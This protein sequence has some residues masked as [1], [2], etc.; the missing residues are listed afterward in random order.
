MEIIKG[1]INGIGKRAAI[2]ASRTNEQIVRRLVE[3]ASNE[4]YRAGMEDGDIVLVEVPG[5]WEIAGCVEKLL[6]N[7]SDS[8]DMV[9]CLG[10]V[11]RGDTPHFEY[12]SSQVAKTI[13]EQGVKSGLPVAFGVLTCDSL[14]QALERSGGKAGNKGEEAARA[15]LEMS[16]IYRKIGS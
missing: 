8:F 3:G 11:I 1:R 5:A 13:A 6:K 2:V 10:A 15:A 16:D 14:D 9:I 7:S 12:V 4:L